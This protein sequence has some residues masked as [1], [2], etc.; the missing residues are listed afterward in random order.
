MFKFMN[1]TICFLISMLIYG[2]KIILKS[3]NIDTKFIIED[4]SDFLNLKQA[5]EN[6]KIIINKLKAE[7]DFEKKKYSELKLQNIRNNIDNRIA[8]RAAKGQY[9]KLCVELE[10]IDI[11]KMNIEKCLILKELKFTVDNLLSIGI[12]KKDYIIRYYNAKFKALYSY[13][14][15]CQENITTIYC[16][17]CS[18]TYCNKCI[19]TY[20]NCNDCKSIMRLCDM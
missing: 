17:P 10:K 5:Y 2:L 14:S 12:D 18:H 11:E 15:I 3:E 7:L 13:C 9:I 19:K 1:D 16:D 8:L 20:Y 6:E 4:N